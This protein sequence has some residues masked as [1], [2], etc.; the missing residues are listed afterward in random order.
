[1]ELAHARLERA[2]PLAHG[3][4]RFV[5]GREREEALQIV[6]G[7]AEAFETFVDEAAVA[8]LERNVG[9][10]EQGA[11][12]G[13]LRDQRSRSGG[14]ITKQDIHVVSITEG[15]EREAFRHAADLLQKYHN[16]E[17]AKLRKE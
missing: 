6:R 10:D 8:Q 1:M 4:R 9:R 17:K 3:G 13:L 11:V 16:S 2:Q 7:G 14:Q 15:T 5:V 12:R